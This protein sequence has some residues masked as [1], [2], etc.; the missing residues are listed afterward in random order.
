[1]V[2]LEDYDDYCCVLMSSSDVRDVNNQTPLHKSCGGAFS[3]SLDMVRYLVERA[4]CDV[5]EWLL[6]LI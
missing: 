6:P 3:A 5:S 2:R 4:H 1:M